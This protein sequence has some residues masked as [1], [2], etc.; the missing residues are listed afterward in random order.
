LVLRLLVLL[1]PQMAVFLCRVQPQQQQCQRCMVLAVAL[2][3]L[4]LL[5]CRSKAQQLPLVH[6]T[7]HRQAK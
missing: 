7:M 4:V 5:V 3:M 6:H 1:L 2:L